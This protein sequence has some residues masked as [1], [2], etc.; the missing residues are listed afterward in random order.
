[1]DSRNERDRSYERRKAAYKQQYRKK[2]RRRRIL[3]NAI[4]IAIRLFAALIV[5]VIAIKV[6]DSLF[7][8]VKATL[9]RQE[10]KKA[11]VTK[12]TDEKKKATKEPTKNE[13]TID[14]LIIVSS[15]NK[16][17]DRCKPQLVEVYATIFVDKSVSEPLQA[18]VEA[19]KQEGIN[20]YVASGYHT[21]DRQTTLYEA[22]VKE[23]IESGTSED[24][25]KE[26][27][28]QEV[29]A[30]DESEHQTGLAVDIT[31]EEDPV[32]D[33]SF[34]DTAA[35]DWLVNHAKDYGFILRY[36]EGKEDTTKMSYDP[37]H[38]R[39]VGKEAAK[40][41]MNKNITLEEYVK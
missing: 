16:R 12:N 17:T 2:K 33:K 5:L 26:K 41:I 21:K 4:V 28:K 34:A 22:K 23:Y 36:P 19:A 24:E 13:Q 38:Y 29:G 8:S 40:E 18:M 37:N 39:Y 6:A 30:P 27:A 15:E 25:A 3:H 7:P 31:V 1:M 9:Q 32:L 35:S 11:S 20:L 10:E 14:P